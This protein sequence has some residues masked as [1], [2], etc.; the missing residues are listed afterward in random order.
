[1]SDIRKLLESIDSIESISDSDSP[2]PEKIA[3]FRELGL[4]QHQWEVFS[5][6]WD[7]CHGHSPNDEYDP[8][9]PMGGPR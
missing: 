3:A 2:D 8:G 6:T 5:M 7:F 4:D 9:N 1:M